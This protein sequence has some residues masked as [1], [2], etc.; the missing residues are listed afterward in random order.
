MNRHALTLIA[1]VC[2]LTFSLGASSS[3]FKE[4]GWGDDLYRTP[5]ARK[6]GDLVTVL[7]VQN[8]RAQQRSE[9][10]EQKSGGLSGRA[11]IA[12]GTGFLKFIKGARSNISINGSSQH[13]REKRV[14]RQVDLIAKVTAQ[15]VETRPN[16]NLKIEGTQH[17]N[18]NGEKLEVYISGVIRPEDI[19]PDNTVLS[20]SMGDAQ[21]EY[22]DPFKPPKRHGRIV[23]TLLLP[24]KAAAFLLAWLF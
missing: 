4:G 3:L 18:I 5:T 19:A 11:D 12:T 15:V 24:I 14:L 13:G 2:L 10:S 21:I 23:R 7:I 8:S 6:V 20:T 1:S 17:V 9:A 16:G 22:R